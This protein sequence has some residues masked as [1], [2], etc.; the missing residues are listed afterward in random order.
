MKVIEINQQLLH[1]AGKLQT[2][3]GDYQEVA[4]YLV[5]ITDYVETTLGISKEQPITDNPP[6][7]YTGD[8]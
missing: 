5:R 2:S 8:K 3:K 1:L 7:L 6:P 4:D